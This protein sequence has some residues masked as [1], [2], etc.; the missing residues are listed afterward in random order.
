MAER[1]RRRQR[2]VALVLVLGIL[3]LLGVGYA[4]ALFLRREPEA[5]PTAACG[6]QRPPSAGRSKPTFNDPPKM[7]IDRQK[8]YSAVVDTSCGTFEVELL[9]DDTP[10]TVNN[11]VFL[12]RE[13]FYDG[14]TFHR[15]IA[16]FMNQAGDPK[17]DGTGG[18]GYQFED[19]IVKSLKFNRPGLLAMANAGPDTNG[20]QFFITV[21]PAGHLDGKH[22]IFGRV[23]RGME[24][25]QRINGLAT[26]GQPSNRPLDTVYLEEV[27]IIEGE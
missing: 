15:V 25:V 6:S 19:E 7:V 24:V 4:G 14:L 9:A 10:L 26:S 3:G 17:G 23:T 20:S 5:E 27:R 12:A 1:K 13:G 16:G 2:M 21:A 8:S 11:F 18:P 22:T